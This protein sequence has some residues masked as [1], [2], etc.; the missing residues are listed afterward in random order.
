MTDRWNRGG[1]EDRYPVCRTLYNVNVV[2]TGLLVAYRNI[3]PCIIVS[4][5]SPCLQVPVWYRD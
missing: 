1:G 2:R 3:F 5:F 4:S